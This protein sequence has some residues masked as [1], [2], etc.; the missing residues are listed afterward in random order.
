MAG[1]GYKD[2]VNGDVLTAT[3]V[4]TYLMEQSVMVF[5]SASA[6]DTALSAV[7]AEGMLTM[8][9]DTNEIQMYDG[10]SWYSINLANASY[11]NQ[12]AV[13]SAVDSIVRPLPFA[14][15]AGVTASI[16]GSATV[17]FPTSTRFTQA[18]IVT[19]TPT[20]STAVTSATVASI[21]TSGFNIYFWSGSSSA[22]LARTAQYMAVQMTTA[23]AQ[24]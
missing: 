19:A 1:A 3:Q 11:P 4:D 10:T 7:K 24:G 9:K 2:F 16:T 18:P 12:V 8:L 21:T 13:K 20:S 15:H 23:A 14:V 6:R 17:S 5:A 22:T